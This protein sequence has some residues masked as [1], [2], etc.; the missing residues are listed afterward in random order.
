MPPSLPGLHPLKPVSS[1]R[2]MVM[3]R[4]LDK[5]YFYLEGFYVEKA[6]RRNFLWCVVNRV[7]VHVSCEK[8][9][10]LCPIKYEL[11]SEAIPGGL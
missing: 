10:G 4:Y 11:A 5:P 6:F 3:D 2:N 8:P 9:R 1:G 7:R